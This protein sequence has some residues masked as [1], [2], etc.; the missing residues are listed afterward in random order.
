MVL[1]V[2][3]NPLAELHGVKLSTTTELALW[4]DMNNVILRRILEKVEQKALKMAQEVERR[5]PNH[6]FGMSKFW[7]EIRLKKEVDKLAE[8][9][10]LT[11]TEKTLLQ[12]IMLSHDLG[13]FVE[14]MEHIE[15]WERP[16]KNHWEISVDILKKDKILAGLPED[17]K[18]IIYFAV[19]WHSTKQS[20]P[21]NCEWEENLDGFRCKMAI[22]LANLLRDMDKIEIIN[23]INKFL[24]P[25]GIKAQVNLHYPSSKGIINEN[26]GKPIKKDI[27]HEALKKFMKHQL[28][29]KEYLTYSYTTYVLLQV[30][31]IFDIKDD[32]LLIRALSSWG[33]KARLRY[34]KKYIPEEQF[35]V[36]TESLKSF[37]L[38]RL[39][40]DK[41]QIILQSFKSF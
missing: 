38:E 15:H 26:T 30:A 1:E 39:G 18:R 25:E 40:K 28:I 2:G 27:A 19:K 20:L 37:I 24:S 7:H 5:Q 8:S 35:N 10:N 41:G 34:L 16:T 21:E 22:K 23:N 32:E 4:L 29:D 11:P 36:V 17:F 13:R 31:L 3:E 9:L 12:I 14:A 6:P 33:F